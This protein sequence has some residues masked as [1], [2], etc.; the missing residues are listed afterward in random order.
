MRQRLIPGRSPAFSSTLDRIEG[1]VACF[2]GALDAG[3]GDL[4]DQLR[5]RRMLGVA[6]LGADEG[7][8]VVPVAEV[9]DLEPVRRPDPRD[10][11]GLERE[12]DRVLLQRVQ[13]IDAGR[14]ESGAVSLPRFMNTP[15][16]GLVTGGFVLRSSSTKA[17]SGPST[18]KRSAVTSSRPRYH[19]VMTVNTISPIT[20]GTQAPWVNLVRFAAEERELHGEEQRRPAHGATAAGASGDAR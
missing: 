2:D 6:V 13:V 7:D 11:H 15:V 8:A 4:P 19:V 10:G 14:I 18:R 5:A 9:V 12:D 3:L 16:P 20:S 1:G 17:C